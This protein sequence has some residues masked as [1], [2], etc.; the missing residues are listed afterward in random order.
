MVSAGTKDRLEEK[1]GMCSKAFPF[2]A[3][4]AMTYLND[5]SSEATSS[6]LS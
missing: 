4:T 2:F 6:L 5:S 3:M 1:H